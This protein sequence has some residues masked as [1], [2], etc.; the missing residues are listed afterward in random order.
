M[1]SSITFLCV[2]DFEYGKHLLSSRLL[3]RNTIIRC[4][5]VYINGTL[6]PP[7]YLGTLTCVTIFWIGFNINIY[8][9]IENFSPISQYSPL[10]NYLLLYTVNPLSKEKRSK[11]TS[12]FNKNK[13][14]HFL[15]IFSC[16]QLNF[17]KPRSIHDAL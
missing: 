14:N 4:E 1:Y 12:I 8:L 11:P 16:S 7:T 3:K 6:T 9:I 5:N 13:T 10:T 2:K 15:F 17:Q